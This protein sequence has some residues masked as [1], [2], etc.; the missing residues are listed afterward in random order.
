MVGKDKGGGKME[1]IN[2]IIVVDDEMGICQNVEKILAKSKYEVVHAQSAEEALERMARESFSLLI[3]DIVMPEMNGLEL[4]KLVKKEWPLTKAI[5]MTAYASTD[6]A[7]KAIRLGALDYI[8]KPFTP[9]E[10][11]ETVRKA[12]SGELVEIKSTPAEKESI[13]IIDVDMP[14]DR[15]E[16]AKYTGETYPDHLTRSD[17]TD[18]EIADPQTIEAYCLVGDMLCDIYKKLGGTCKGGLKNKCPQKAKAKKA[19]SK[20][21]AV[22]TKKLI[23]IDQPFD[24]EEVVSITGP[25]YV[26][27]MDRDGFAFMPYE[28]LKAKK[29]TAP[30]KSVGA[31]DVDIPFDREEVAKY[32]GEVYADTLTRSDTTSAKISK[33]EAMEFFCEIGDMVCEIFKKMGGTCKAG[34]K[35]KCPQKKAKAK[36]GE[37]KTVRADTSRLISVDMPFDYEEVAAVTGPE[38]VQYLGREDMS[39]MPYA[40]LKKKAALADK[41]AEQKVQKV[42]DYPGLA[43]EPT[44]RNTL[45]IDD[46]VA[47]NNNIRKILASEGYH[48]DQAVTKAEALES[49]N[50]H[51]YQVIL[52]DLRIPGVKGLELLQV[53]AEKQPDAKVIIITG[54]A[55]IDTAVEAARIGAIDYIPK[56]F[57]PDEIRNAAENA[58]KLAA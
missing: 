46:E 37:A 49:I 24:Y 55:S 34:L 33:P 52:L 3:S 28:A 14:F 41:A 19:A 8:P 45:V 16:V 56:P 5:M 35:N 54:Y 47:V 38:Y 27:Y 22:D 29:M 42:L 40:E 31:I 2:K 53:I 1:N 6:T 25:E 23:G 30:S 50:R 57:T 18:S 44:Y 58:F 43:G 20:K 26:Q 10:L 17:T 36:K 51:P 7:M 4:L 12:M 32:T 11:R 39:V 15:D 9:S 13:D 48:V 21:E